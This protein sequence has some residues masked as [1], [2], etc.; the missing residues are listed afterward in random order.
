MP[1]PSNYHCQCNSTVPKVCLVKICFTAPE[2]NHTC[3]PS[4]TEPTYVKT[5]QL[6]SIAK[7]FL[8]ITSPTANRPTYNRLQHK[9]PSFKPTTA[10]PPRNNCPQETTLTKPTPTWKQGTHTTSVS[11]NIYTNI[12]KPCTFVPLNSSLLF[13]HSSC[14]FKFS[15]L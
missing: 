10:P 3:P 5:R 11:I 8:I 15:P 6:T 7:P 12:C 2:D 4:Y 1:G 13:S 14:H 9:S